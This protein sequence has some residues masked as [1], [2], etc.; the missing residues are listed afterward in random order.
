MLTKKLR[1][2]TLGFFYDCRLLIKPDRFFVKC[3]FLTISV[4]N[5][6]KFGLTGPDPECSGQGDVKWHFV[7]LNLFQHQLLGMLY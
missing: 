2:Y 4:M 5:N 7:M 6:V 1:V 3:Q